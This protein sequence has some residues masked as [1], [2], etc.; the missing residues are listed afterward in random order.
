MTTKRCEN[1]ADQIIWSFLLKWSMR[2]GGRLYSTI[3][4]ILTNLVFVQKILCF[5]LFLKWFLFCCVLIHPFPYDQIRYSSTSMNVSVL[6]ECFYVC[7]FVCACVCSSC[8]VNI[9]WQQLVI[10]HG[11]NDINQWAFK[12]SHLIITTINGHPW[13]H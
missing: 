7:V 2:N 10:T 9:L 12:T 8:V 1:W 5:L 11:A 4:F 6:D 13:I 3:I